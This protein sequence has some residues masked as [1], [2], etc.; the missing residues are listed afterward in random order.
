[1]NRSDFCTLRIGPGHV[2]V[3]DMRDS[4]KPPISIFAS[5][6]E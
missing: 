1:V 4:D 3:Y 5:S 2:V 6:G